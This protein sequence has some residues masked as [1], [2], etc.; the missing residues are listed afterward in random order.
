MRVERGTAG[1]SSAANPKGHRSHRT[2]KIAFV[3]VVT[4]GR[5]EREYKHTI[6][7]PESSLSPKSKKKWPCTRRILVNNLTLAISGPDSPP[8]NMDIVSDG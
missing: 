2:L 7:T 8:D 5:R 6:I 1:N 3:H 4:K